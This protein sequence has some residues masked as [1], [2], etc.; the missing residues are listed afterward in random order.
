MLIKNLQSN[1]LT[2]KD[3][4][5][6]TDENG[7]YFPS[8]T[9]ILEAYPK[10]AQLIMWMKEVGSK[11]D[12]IRDAAGKRG[13]AVHQLTEDYDNGV[14]CTLLDEYGKPKYSLDEW[15][16]FERY[17]EFSVNHKPEHHLIEQTFIGGS[18]GFAGTID[19]ICTIDGKTYVLD[20]KTSNGIYNSY[21][22]QL[23]AYRELYNNAK[24]AWNGFRVIKSDHLP[25]IDGVAILWLNS[26]TRTSG[27]K[28]DV[29]GKGWQM[30]TE[31]DTTKQWSLFQAVQQLWHAE[32][33]G[34]KPKEFSYQLS[35]KK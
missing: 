15:S 4:R 16:M 10:P 13:S 25:D 27:K 12:E 11:A 3:G 1:Q 34:D 35:H 9:T 14:E 5:F 26:K 6:Y 19:R 20:I 7:N 24:T 21:W 29:Q 22:L 30:V 8:A 23:A 33:E 17:V 18:L 28:G 31:M 32:H 2:F